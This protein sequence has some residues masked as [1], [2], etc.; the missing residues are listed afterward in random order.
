M[1]NKINSVCVYVFCRDENKKTYILAGRRASAEEMRKIIGLDK[2]NPKMY[3]GANKY[4]PP[5][6]M[7][8]D[9]ENPIDAA[10]R[11]CLEETGIQLSKN[12]IKIFDKTKYTVNKNICVGLNCFTVLPGIITDYTIGKGDGENHKFQ[13]LPIKS[14]NTFQWAFNTNVK[15][16]EIVEHIFTIKKRQMQNDPNRPKNKPF[17][18]ETFNNNINET[19]MSK[20]K[21][22]ESTI[23]RIVRES[24]LEYFKYDPRNPYN[25]TSYENIKDREETIARD[26]LKKRQ[27]RN[28]YDAS[29]KDITYEN[30]L[31]SVI[32]KAVMESFYNYNDGYTSSTSYEADLWNMIVEKGDHDEDG[33]H[34]YLS[35]GIKF[36]G[37]ELEAIHTVGS[38]QNGLEVFGKNES[39]NFSELPQE[40][41]LQIFKDVREYEPEMYD[42]EL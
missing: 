12:H 13:W 29:D 31:K 2:F 8:E 28:K 16:K 14:I 41:Q 15:I 26:L 4:N 3:K 35:P 30:K 6:G 24:L 42:D 34:I 11:E 39:H 38:R 22:T 10:V 32:N 18:F 27:E 7:V 17:L 1:E 21:L 9:G 36:N 20:I 25:D 23:K 33:Y 37:E 40:I 5:M 19:N